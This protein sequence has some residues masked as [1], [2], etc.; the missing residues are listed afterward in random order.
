MTTYE[1]CDG[2]QSTRQPKKSAKALAAQRGE[3]EKPARK[4]QRGAKPAAAVAKK[5]RAKPPVDVEEMSASDDEGEES[6]DGSVSVH[7]SSSDE[8]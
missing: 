1:V 2:S 8:E 6:S 7:N 3:A 4:K 5:P